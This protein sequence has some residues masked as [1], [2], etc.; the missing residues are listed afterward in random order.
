MNPVCRPGAL[1]SLLLLAAVAL[2]GVAAAQAAD[3]I[4]SKSI[5]RVHAVQGT[6]FVLAEDGLSFSWLNLFNSSAEVRTVE[7]PWDGSVEDGVPWRTS[8]L[9]RANYPISDSQRVAR[10]ASAPA[11]ALLNTSPLALRGDS[12]IFKDTSLA[13]VRGAGLTAL[14][15]RGDTALLGFGRL[16]LAYVRLNGASET[17]GPLFLDTTV[18]FRGFPGSDS[19]TAPLITCRWNRLC[20]A[21]TITVPG[22]G[23]DSVI[24]L[25][26][27]T[28][29]GGPWILIATQKG[30][31]RGAWRGTNFPYVSLPGISDAAPVPVRTVFASPSATRA[32]AFTGSKFFYSD[33]HGATFRVPPSQP[34]TTGVTSSQFTS[35]ATARPPQ[36]AFTGDTTFINFN[37]DSVGVVRFRKDSLQVNVTGS[38][39][40]QALLNA[41]DSLDVGDE[42]SLTGLAVARRAGNQSVL[43]LGTTRQGI[44]Y[45]RLDLPGKAFTN[46]T[47]RAVLKGGLAEVITYPTLFEGPGSASSP[48]Y[49]RI[50]YRLKKSGR[51]TITIYNY[52]ME[53]VRVVVRNVPRQGGVPRSENFSEDRWDGRDSAGRLVSVGTYYVRV[54]SDQGEAAFGKVIC[55]RGR[56]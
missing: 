38:G 43:V 11:A 14:A 25:A 15:V 18:S 35:Y 36:V 6:V 32:W 54:E 20:R 44:F 40:N 26:V 4:A 39:L 42:E 21:D 5:S 8:M 2:P 33:D 47:S 46:L 23:L 28:T 17:S 52:A 30:L 51:V 53:K 19:A 50:G 55:V 16:G 37:M 24:S 41:N 7:W 29:A 22:G 9:L 1:A 48:E 10:A 3:R 49:V 12:L 13:A 34:L 27:D 45:R 56:R 31:R